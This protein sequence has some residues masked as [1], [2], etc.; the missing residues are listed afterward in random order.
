M[1][2]DTM[3]KR[4]EQLLGDTGGNADTVLVGAVQAISETAWR[5]AD[6]FR[7]QLPRKLAK[8][9]PAGPNQQRTLDEFIARVGELSGT[10]DMAQAREYAQ[11][12]FTVLTEAIS[13]GQLR[14]LMEAL[15]AEYGALVPGLS[16]L[17]G[18]EETLLAEVRRQAGLADAE[19]ARLLTQAVLV[20]L[21][22]AAS[23][24]QAAQLAT[25]LPGDLADFLKTSEQAQH[26]DTDRFLSEVV[27]RS[28]VTTADTVRDHTAAVFKG[29]RQWAPDEL[30]D[31]LGQLPHPLA[32]LSV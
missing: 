13:A 31:T 23:G 9:G 17:T 20:V 7:A 18:D 27:N 5:E 32:Q 6:D 24:G 26:T 21:G 30:A 19:Q 14:Q 15:P 4:L 28:A 1:Q 25:A 2:Y 11:A 3:I 16:G 10:V 12:S 29:V 22:E 8:T